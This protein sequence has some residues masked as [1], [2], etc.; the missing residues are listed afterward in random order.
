LHLLPRFLL[1]RIGV[2]SSQRRLGIRRLLPLFLETGDVRGGAGPM[3]VRNR[4]ENDC[5]LGSPDVRALASPHNL[6][7]VP[8][9]V[10]LPYLLQCGLNSSHQKF[11]TG[12]FVYSSCIFEFWNTICFCATVQYI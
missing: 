1:S 5:R 2:S 10:S 11:E 3:G 6:Q 4:A 7:Y 9:R 8:C 12:I